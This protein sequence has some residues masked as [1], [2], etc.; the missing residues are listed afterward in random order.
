MYL[1]MY[2]YMAINFCIVLFLLILLCNT[3][4]ENEII[5]HWIIITTIVQLINS[6]SEEKETFLIC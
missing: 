6:Q 4:P 1:Y 3:N 5:G 2:M